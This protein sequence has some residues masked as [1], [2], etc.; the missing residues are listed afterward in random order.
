MNDFM[1]LINSDVSVGHVLAAVVAA[2]AA[3]KGGSYAFKGVKSVASK[4]NPTL[5]TSALLF[6]T[7]VA[8]V[9]YSVGD[10]SARSEVKTQEAAE[11][12]WMSNAQLQ[13]FSA[14]E[15]VEVVREILSFHKEQRQEQIAF[16][17]ETRDAE[18]ADGVVAPE[19]TLVAMT[20][21]SDEESAEI[22]FTLLDGSKTVAS[23]TDSKIVDAP[24]LP[25]QGTLGLLGLC[26]SV[27]I[28]GVVTFLR[29]ADA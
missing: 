15:N 1:S 10:I 14:T 26:I 9:G 5:L 3:Y 6:M 18:D 27:I 20:S 28:T 7:G 8:G 25:I 12:Q 4:Y 11:V 22:D 21:P 23:V 2:F 13:A 24:H 19:E 17:K 16:V 29:Q